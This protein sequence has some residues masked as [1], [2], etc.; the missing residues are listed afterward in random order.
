M[1]HG[2]AVAWV[3]G[4]TLEAA[5]LGA[6][7]VVVDHEPLPSLVTITEAIAAGSFQGARPTLERGDVEAGFAAST[8]VFEGVTHGFDQQDRAAISTLQF[9]P[10]AAAEALRTAGDF[11]DRLA[12]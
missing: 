8:R 11:L 1:F 12:R 4:E 10:E 3:L 7:A 6:L 9:D 5:R 2:Q